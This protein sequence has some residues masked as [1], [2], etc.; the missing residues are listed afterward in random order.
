VANSFTLIAAYSHDRYIA[1]F[2]SGNWV[3]KA[4]CL[5]IRAL[6]AAEGAPRADLMLAYGDSVALL[7]KWSGRWEGGD[8]LLR[9]LQS[10]LQAEFAKDQNSCAGGKPSGSHEGLQLD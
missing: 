9:G 2:L 4:G 3:H 7:G 5:I 10:R 1:T 6:F 8:T